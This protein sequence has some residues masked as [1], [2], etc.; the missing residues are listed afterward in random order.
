M[1]SE[2]LSMWSARGQDFKIHIE[3][4]LARLARRASVISE[5]TDSWLI[6]QKNQV[7]TIKANDDRRPSTETTRF[8]LNHYDHAIRFAFWLHV[9]TCCI[10]AQGQRRG[11][12]KSEPT[13]V[14]IAAA[15]VFCSIDFLGKSTILLQSTSATT[16][17]LCRYDLKCPAIK[18]LCRA[19]QQVTDCIPVNEDCGVFSGYWERKN[20]CRASD[21]RRTVYAPVGKPQSR[22]SGMKACNNIY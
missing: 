11:C 21:Q 19:L 13:M 14:H 12:G 20:T 3:L 8:D 5:K 15:I 17:I 4:W 1:P 10:S 9:Q 7:R 2:T 6:L 18:L 16:L 22:F